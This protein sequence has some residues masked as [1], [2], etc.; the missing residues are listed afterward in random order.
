MK[1]VLT[2]FALVLCTWSF[3]SCAYL[4]R[5]GHVNREYHFRMTV[6][7]NGQSP[8]DEDIKFTLQPV[9]NNGDQMVVMRTHNYQSYFVIL[10][11]QVVLFLNKLTGNN[12]PIPWFWD[13]F[14]WLP[15]T[16]WGADRSYVMATLILLL[17]HLNMFEMI[18]QLEHL[19]WTNSQEQTVLVIPGSG[20]QPDTQLA[21][22]N[23]DPIIT[24]NSSNGNVQYEL[25]EEVES[26]TGGSLDS[27]HHDDGNDDGND[28]HN[29]RWPF[30]KGLWSWL[31]QSPL[32]PDTG[33]VKNIYG[34][35]QQLPRVKQI[36]VLFFLGLYSSESAVFY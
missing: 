8:V 27:S 22:C 33:T 18:H 16:S 1:R 31:P 30:W 15:V 17:R 35:S 6:S 4:S 34:G 24:I 25:Q 14:S 11:A 20:N 5:L 12:D 36:N 10:S 13:F 23:N 28:D 7:S 2:L 32:S 21:I 29:D 9:D 26:K 3:S 19:E